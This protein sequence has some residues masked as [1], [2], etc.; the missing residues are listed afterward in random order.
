[1]NDARHA[2]GLARL[3]I[4]PRLQRTSRGHSAYMLRTDTF[5]HGAFAARIR[6]AGVRAPR[7][8]ENLA[9]A[10][11]TL[12][13]GRLEP[14]IL[15]PSRPEI[16]DPHGGHQSFPRGVPSLGLTALAQVCAEMPVLTMRTEP[17]PSPTSAPLP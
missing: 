10:V 8:G 13:A 11:G 12:A 6:R 5:A 2:H 15:D 1:M 4:D 9:W 3:R 16:L 17:S 14:T 7:I